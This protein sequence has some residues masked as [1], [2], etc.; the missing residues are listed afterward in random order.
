MTTCASCGQELREGARFCPNCGARVQQPE[1]QDAPR[2]SE[3]EAPLITLPDEP[4]AQR[5]PRASARRWIWI[6]GAALVAIAAV[7]A[8]LY[9]VPKYFS[10]ASSAS[11]PLAGPSSTLPA[12]A[13]PPA[14][15]SPTATSTPSTVSSPSTSPQT[16]A[17]T[18]AAPVTQPT[19]PAD[20]VAAYYAAVSTHDYGKAWDLGGKNFGSTFADFSAGYASTARQILTIG[21]APP[22]AGQVEIRLLAFT[23][24]GDAQLFTGTY[25]V[26]GGTIVSGRLA[27]S[28]E[29]PAAQFAGTPVVQ[30]LADLGYTA[31][32]P[33]PPQPNDDLDAVPAVCSDSGD[34][35]CQI[36]FFFHRGQMVGVDR[37]QGETSVSIAWQNGQVAA[38]V[39]PQYGA[40][41]PMCCASGNPVTVQFGWNGSDAVPLTPLPAP[42]N[43]R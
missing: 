7:A 9:L 42:I 8:G 14:S 4:E 20:V 30:Q 16:T 37:P 1:A 38:A 24:Q 2:A 12:S 5:E 17:S 22:S 33:I 35:H 13:S 10:P 28:F 36:V 6:A 34:G 40:N 3:P 23:T 43:G 18:S 21:H 15:S 31:A 29:E 41:D 27:E 19:T 11:Q 32:K 25:T 26:D 39:Y